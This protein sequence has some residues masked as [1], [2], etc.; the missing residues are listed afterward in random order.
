M[1]SDAPTK[2]FRLTHVG[3]RVADIDRSVSFYTG[4]FGMSELAR[5][6]LDTTTVV[7][8][9]YP[10]AAS[11]DTPLFAREGVLELVCSKVTAAHQKTSWQMANI[12]SRIPRK[13]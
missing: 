12:V 3:L 2:G 8:L 10:D 6:P 4:V 13:Q 1:S 11:P 7:F 5:M 9:G